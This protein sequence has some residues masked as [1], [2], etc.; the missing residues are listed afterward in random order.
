MNTKLTCLFLFFAL[1]CIRLGAQ[2]NYIAAK[3]SWV[4]EVQLPDEK[5]DTKAMSDGYYYFMNDYQVHVPSKHYYSHFAYKIYN[6]NGVESAS[7]LLFNYNPAYEKIKI[8]SVKIRRGQDCIDKTKTLD[9]KVL[10]RETNLEKNMYDERLTLSTVLE[11]VRQG[12][13]VEYDYSIIGDNPIFDNKFYFSFYGNYSTSCKLIH[14]RILKPHT[15]TLYV[16]SQNS[17]RD[18]IYS[19]E[20]G[21]ECMTWELKD[22][23]A[24]VMDPSAPHEYDPYELIE[25]SEYDDW[26]DVAKWAEKVFA[27]QFAPSKELKE[28]VKEFQAIESKDKQVMAVLHFVQNEIR[29]FGVEIGVNSHKPRNP[30]DVF[31]TRYGDCK[32]KVQL[33]RYF[34]SELGM[35]ARP[36]L[37]H[38]VNRSEITKR[39]VSPH[40]FDHVIVEVTPKGWHYYFDATINF[41][42]GNL[43]NYYT[44]N[45]RTG[46]V[47]GDSS[48]AII[49]FMYTRN[50]DA[51]LREHYIIHSTKGD[52]TLTAK[53]FYHGWTADHNRNLFSNK[54]NYEIAEDY[55]NYYKK[56]FGKVESTEDLVIKD[57]KENNIFTVAETYRIKNIWNDSTSRQGVV[58]AIFPAHFLL[59]EINKIDLSLEKRKDPLFLPHPTWVQHIIDIDLPE[60]WDINTEPVSREN[61]YFTYIKEITYIKSTHKLT[62]NFQFKTRQTE[63]PAAVYEDFRTDLQFVQ[64]DIYYSLYFNKGIG[65]ELASSSF[66]AITFG[67]FLFVAQL[68][69]LLMIFLYRKAFFKPAQEEVPRVLGG[70]LVPAM[71][72]LG[73]Y[74]VWLVYCFVGGEYFSKAIWLTYT[75]ET[76]LNY[77][78]AYAPIRMFQLIMNEVFLFYSVFLFILI[79]KQSHLVPKL[80]V[81]YIVIFIF[82]NIFDSIVVFVYIDRT[83]AL[84][85]GLRTLVSMMAGGIFIPFFLTSERAKETFIR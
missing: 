19:N 59:E 33:V 49:G 10:Q 31:R 70:M 22:T 52:A 53:S 67:T 77:V 65:K 15:Q 26:K 30:N 84:W 46:L 42:E 61:A 27:L 14:C 62:L 81:A 73:A 9:L 45:Y 66:N 12:D 11:D 41:Q 54:S 25:I 50:F 16:T 63:V 82:Y 38:S 40:Q 72:L 8:H 18:P 7:S 51:K 39:A 80:V 6:A 13:V 23:K 78:K 32:D 4:K 58:A 5:M 17:K 48:A 20:S 2:K 37:V 44:P 69:I 79:V 60:S 24:Y 36:V 1:I 3:P 21:L 47:S 71:V 34:L 76:S 64:D 83:E 43:Q 75:D 85:D 29:Y 68:L 74:A 56:M 55:S 35:L 57:S 28:K